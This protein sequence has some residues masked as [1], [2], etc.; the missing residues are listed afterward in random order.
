[1]RIRLSK[2]PHYFTQKDQ[3]LQKT[4]K[5]TKK[6]ESVVHTQEKKAINRDCTQEH[7]DVGLTRQRL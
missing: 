3:F 6:Q 1:M 7:P 5:Y 4:Y 2:L